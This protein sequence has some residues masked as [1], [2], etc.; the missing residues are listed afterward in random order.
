MKKADN[1]G[2]W[3]VCLA[4]GLELATFN[5]SMA[6]D[7]AS[8]WRDAT[9]NPAAVL[10]L[11]AAALESRIKAATA[12]KAKLPQLPLTTA[13]MVS[14][15]KAAAGAAKVSRE[16]ECRKRGPFCRDREADERVALAALSTAETN[17]A[18]TDAL[19]K[20]DE[21]IKAAEKEKLELGPIPNNVDPGAA[22]IGK[23]LAKFIDMGPRP[24]LVVIDWWPTFVAVMI[25]A[26]GLLLPRIILTATG[27]AD[28][29][30]PP[31][32][33]W[34][35]SPPDTPAAP[36]VV[37]L[38]AVEIAAPKRTAATAARPTNGSKPKPT[39]AGDADTVRLWQRSRTIARPGSKLKPLETYDTSYV[40]FC[41]ERGLEPVSFTRFG[42]V[43]K[44]PPA[45]GGCG[46]GFERTKS[47][48]DHYLD[49]ALISAPKLVAQG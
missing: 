2:F 8:R 15:A 46:F 32:W 18:N 11:K 43:V 5:Y 4:M 27:T 45:A 14:A 33:S 26:I 3:L 25:E 6:V 30:A 42:M 44:A 47:K 37:P 1:L 10:Q 48:R 35:R 23:L 29:P 12:A 24:D 19:A 36:V 9:S 22:K 28:A 7:L 49:V 40:P 39:A 31:R 34:R 17:R 16:D 13:A 20:F 41:K 21:E 38:A